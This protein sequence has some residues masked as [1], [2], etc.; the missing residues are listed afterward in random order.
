MVR[1]TNI[2]V[3]LCILCVP[4]WVHAKV[5][6]SE[7][8]WMGSE[9]NANAEWIELYN[10][11]PAT[12]VDGW[13]LV[14]ADDQPSLTLSGTMAADSYALLERTS[15]ETVPGRRAFLV[16]T[17]AL[18]NDGETLELYTADGVRED[19]VQ[20]GEGWELGGNNE[21]KDTLQ[22]SG[23]PAVGAW[24]TGA[25]TPGRGGGVAASPADSNSKPSLVATPRNKEVEDT[26]RPVM[27][28]PELGLV[29]DDPGTLTAGVPATFMARTHRESGREVGVD[30]ARWVFGDG[31]TGSGRNVSH[32]Y[33]YPGTYVVRVA[34]KDDAFRTPLEAEAELVVTVVEAEYSIVDASE[35]YIEIQNNGTHAVNLSQHALAVGE[36]Y[37]VF[38][39]GT[40]L[41]P[42]RS[43][44]FPMVHT[45]L[46]VHE[47]QY[48]GLY[49]PARTLVHLYRA[50]RTHERVQATA[51]AR[52]EEVAPRVVAAQ[53]T[54]RPGGR[55]GV[56]VDTDVGIDVDELLRTVER[57]NTL[58]AGAHVAQAFEPA[59]AASEKRENLLVWW[60][61]A[62]AALIG[63]VLVVIALIRHEQAEI[64]KGYEIEEV[65]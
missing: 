37:F 15:D 41:L 2:A 59:D 62:L 43:V 19:R 11:G 35:E 1:K 27:R 47:R 49:T 17:G 23:A 20:G 39:E 65:S 57:P 30:E 14:A 10:D 38:P 4:G 60:L 40:E 8:A 28:E 61:A 22:R 18:G 64:V 53:D 48:V 56:D 46:T 58:Q 16:Y 45:H 55:V 24:I 36:D 33:A 54:E 5:Y 32:T 3:L 52:A 34:A 21:T 12:R 13:V 63:T 9:E 50:P 44:R 42:E 26:P 51:A 25:R 6:I 29:L 31:A 7:V